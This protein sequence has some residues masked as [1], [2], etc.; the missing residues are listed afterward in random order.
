MP[1]GIDFKLDVAQ[2]TPSTGLLRVYAKSD[3]KLYTKNPAGAEVV[4][5]TSAEDLTTSDGTTNADAG[6]LGEY[7]E[8]SVGSP[9]TT[10]SGHTTCVSLTLSAGDWDVGGTAVLY[11]DAATSTTQ[12]FCGLHT[13]ANVQAPATQRFRLSFASFTPGLGERFNFPVPMVRYL[14]TSST[15]IYLNILS[16]A[17]GGNAYGSGKIWARRRR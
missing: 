6:K 1:R 14:L 11:Y 8:A 3:N 12:V 10:L 2:A 15:T 4:L 16:G 13:T 17:S 9:G 5:A 7:Q